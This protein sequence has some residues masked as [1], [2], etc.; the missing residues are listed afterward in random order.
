[1]LTMVPCDRGYLFGQWGQVSQLCSTGFGW[2]RVSFHHGGCYGAVFLICAEYRV[3][4]TELFLLLLSLLLL[5]RRFLLF[6]LETNSFQHK[7][8]TELHTSYCGENCL[9]PSQKQHTISDPSDTINSKCRT[10]FPGTD[11]YWLS[12][13]SGQKKNLSL[14]R[15]G[16]LLLR[17]LESIW[18]CDKLWTSFRMPQVECS[19]F[20]CL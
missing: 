10:F 16:Q 17:E 15:A 13:L 19:L 3:D 7:S 4:N 1:M 11:G 8:K 20:L 6:M 18:P 14:H 5:P 2:G 12:S 9:C